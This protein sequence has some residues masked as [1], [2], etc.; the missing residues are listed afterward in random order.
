GYMRETGNLIFH[1]ALV[2][3]LAAV[4]IGGAFGYTGQRLLVEGQTFANTLSAYDSFTP[5]RFFQESHLSPYALTLKQLD[6]HYE[7]EHETAFGLAM[8]YTAHV[9]ARTL[10]DEVLESTVKVNWPL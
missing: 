7:T 2:G 5:G 4:G 9:D 8:D 3:V 10:G 6:V 1:T